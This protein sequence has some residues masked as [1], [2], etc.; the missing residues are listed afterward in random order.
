MERMEMEMDGTKNVP[1]E[2]L[3]VLVASWLDI[4]FELSVNL[5]KLGSG[6][7]LCLA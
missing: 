6:G 2:D 4:S 5:S 7:G 1:N 3:A